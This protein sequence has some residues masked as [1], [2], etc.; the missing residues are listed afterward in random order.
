MDKS[1]K[2]FHLKNLFHTDIQSYL[3]YL[4]VTLRPQ[5][6]LDYTYDLKNFF[7]YLEDNMTLIDHVYLERIDINI[8]IYYLLT[9]NN[10]AT[11]RRYLST[12]KH[13]YNYLYSVYGT[14]NRIKFFKFPSLD[15]KIIRFI[16]T[17]QI[18][19]I[20]NDLNNK[21]PSFQNQRD[22]LI[23][24]LLLSTGIRLSELTAINLNDVESENFRIRITQ[25]GGS[26]RYIYLSDTLICLLNKYLVLRTNMATTKALF[27]SNR[28]QRISNRTVELII[29]KIGIQN[30]VEITPHILRH[31]YATALYDKTEDLLLVSKALG[32]TN[33]EVT[34]RYY[35]SFRNERLKSIRNLLF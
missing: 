2:I 1:K 23:F 13:L 18:E 11:K 29:Q 14:P 17:S 24:Y 9:K 15:Q 27:I 5:T 3:S 4:E 30:G 25:K 34:K 8:F 35:I 7:E 12:F 6:V 33:I 28:K 19:N 31:T 22:Y 26:E 10:A 16:T 32:H 20:L 21:S